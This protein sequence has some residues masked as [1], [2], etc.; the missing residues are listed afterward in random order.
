MSCT[1]MYYIGRYSYTREQMHSH[2]FFIEEIQNIIMEYTF[3][4]TN[5][6]MTQ[7]EFFG[8]DDISHFTGIKLVFPS[9][10]QL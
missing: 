1:Y 3:C 5:L 4:Y 2:R 8:R 6:L 7:R 10:N 9:M